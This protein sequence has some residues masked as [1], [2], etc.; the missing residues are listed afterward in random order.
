MSHD[1]LNIRG[2]FWLAWIV[3]DLSRF[4]IVLSLVICTCVSA[5]FLILKVLYPKR[6]FQ[7]LIKG[8]P[9]GAEDLW[10]KRIAH[11]SYNDG[12][13][14]VL[15]VTSTGTQ[16]ISGTV[17]PSLGPLSGFYSKMREHKNAVLRERKLS[18]PGSQA[19]ILAREVW[20][21]VSLPRECAIESMSEREFDLARRIGELVAILETEY[22]HGHTR[23][24][25]LDNRS[26]RL[27]SEIENFFRYN[28]ARVPTVVALEQEKKGILDI[29]PFQADNCM[30]A[31]R[32]EI[33]H[34]RFGKW[35]VEDVHQAAI[36][37]YKDSKVD[38][39]C[40]LNHL[41]FILKKEGMEALTEGA[42]VTRLVILEDEEDLKKLRKSYEEG[43]EVVHDRIDNSQTQY[44]L[45]DRAPKDLATISNLDFAL[46][47][48]D[49]YGDGLC[50][51]SEFDGRRKSIAGQISWRVH[52]IEF[53]R[54]VFNGL[55]D[56]SVGFGA[57]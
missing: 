50:I 31:M 40:Y 56:G 6:Y 53:Y 39:V 46:V 30:R 22:L 7:L 16:V 57:L 32:E 1:F 12:N 21:V 51:K 9:I 15:R 19:N 24:E 35:P 25:F 3:V 26:P 23:C 48:N 28:P 55:K 36:E 42:Q 27:R 44:V 4:L 10:A 29:V 52:E 54:R 34:V 45:L 2:P 18:I 14:V 41:L 49:E 5:I 13:E 20:E 11:V 43:G 38:A 47:D 17:K 8:G 37:L 33:E